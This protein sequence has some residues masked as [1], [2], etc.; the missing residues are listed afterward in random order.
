MA[1]GAFSGYF[2]D[3]SDVA[4]GVDEVEGM[5]P[6]QNQETSSSKVA[7]PSK[8]SAKNVDAYFEDAANVVDSFVH[9]NDM[10]TTTTT[11]SVATARVAT[12]VATNVASFGEEATTLSCSNDSYQDPSFAMDDHFE[13]AMAYTMPTV[14]V[15]KATKDAI[16]GSMHYMLQVTVEPGLPTCIPQS[17]GVFHILI[18]NF[19]ESPPPSSYLYL[20]LKK[21]STKLLEESPLHSSSSKEQKTH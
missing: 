12:I 15:A 11:A 17:V 9:C 8:S 1:E 3:A 2:G 18:E 16:D 20:Y 4:R 5:L 10:L 21:D 13:Q 6:F 19:D 7:G 14:V